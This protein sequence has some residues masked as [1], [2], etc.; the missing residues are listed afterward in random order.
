MIGFIGSASAAVTIKLGTLAPPDSYW[1]DVLMGLGDS[2]KKISNGE[3]EVKIYAGGTVGDDEGM[4]R[5]MRLNQLDAVAMSIGS[6]GRIYSGVEALSWP[7]LI[8]TTEEAQYVLNEMTPFLNQE[9]EK[10]GFVSPIWSFIGWTHFFSR[11]PVTSNADLLKQKLRVDDANVEE[12]RSWQ[13]AGFDVVSLPIPEVMIGLQ[14]SM[15][16]AYVSSPAA[17]AAFQWFGVAPHMHAMRFAPLFGGLVISKRSWSK[18]PQKYHAPFLEMAQHVADR[19][20]QTALYVDGQALKI[21]QGFGL[22][23]H[24][25]TPQMEEDWDR[26]LEEHFYYSLIESNIIDSDAYMKVQEALAIFRANNTTN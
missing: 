20:S 23:V 9:M 18:I 21:M 25:S 17:S 7:R 10:Q 16:D 11:T 5:K 19:L 8:R 2:W 22:Q 14:T 12:V 1:N 26:I 15:I 4:I 24:A 13:S 3:V 6:I